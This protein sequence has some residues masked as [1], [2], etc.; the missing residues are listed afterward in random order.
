MNLKEISVKEKRPPFD[1]QGDRVV[2]NV[3]S[4]P[5]FGG[6]NAFDVLGKTPRLSVD[7][8]TK[9]I[10]I[11]GKTGLILYQN[12]R[13]L[14]L[15]SDQVATY[16]QSLP[17]NIISRIEVLTSPS[18]QYDAGSSGVIL[19]YTKG[20]NRQGITGELAVT[21]GAG[22][23]GKG[24]ASA[25]LSFQSA[26]VQGSFLYAPTYRPTYYSWRSD[27]VLPSLTTGPAGFAHSEEFNQ[28]ENTSHLI[29]TSWDWKAA[30]RLTLGTVLQVTHTAETDNPTSSI[31]YQ[32][33]GVDASISRLDAETQLSQQ[34][35]NLAAN[36]NARKQFKN[37]EN[38]LALDLD[39]ARYNVNSKSTATFFQLFP[40]FQ[41]PENLQ[42]LYPNEV[43]IRTAKLDYRSTLLT[44][45]RLESGF[46][47]SW[48]SMINIP[49]LETF[50]P[51]FQSLTP[52]LT[53]P[54]Q[55]QEQIAAAYSNWVFSVKGWSFQT[56]LR[57][58][59][60]HYEGLSGLSTPI[61]RD[62]LNIFPSVNVQ[63]TSMRK[64]QYSMSVN[65]RINRPSFDQLN[66]AYIFY[67]PL[68]LYS[69]NPLLMPQLATT[70]QG[71]YTTSKRINVTVVYSD[72]RNRIT[73]VVY[74]PDLRSPAT[75]DYNQNFDWE[76]RVSATLSIPIKVTAG[77]RI[78]GLVTAAN[79]RFFS[80][81][82]ETPFLNKQ[83]TVTL[84]LNNTFTWK[85]WSANVNGTYRGLAVVGY[86]VYDP[87][88]FVDLGV[89][90]PLSERATIKL[91]ASDIFHTLLINNYG[92]YLNTTIGFKHKYESQQVLL[93]YSY[94]F[95][96]R[97]AKLVEQRSFGSESE[98]ERLGNKRN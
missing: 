37:A 44:R 96:N 4:N 65:R 67:D 88:W 29:R 93:T 9:S 35:S 63:F 53:K 14:Y 69:G 61:N 77:W 36:V 91:A 16:L 80:T 68:T 94:Q 24:N 39:I 75:L 52:L 30:R 51:Y 49:S 74:R 34:I 31:T 86:M 76:K 15:S 20:F 10:T 89:Q 27:Q 38:T 73:E 40:T 11:D 85:K 45:G 25:N 18:A 42:I 41:K 81:F 57:L 28:I 33:P 71:A 21:A 95:G 47:Y 82:Q 78:Q 70:L 22:R 48:I 23:Y 2:V 87:I 58:E 92:S 90:R 59:H 26:N 32:L 12:G 50:T 97:K 60:T 62:Y 19:L 1:L 64:N 98:Q 84:R 7:A 56:G 55:Y 83:S 13:Q 79:V 46:K 5:V 6:G 43:W 3:E 8:V 54:Y 66:P 17:A 72:I